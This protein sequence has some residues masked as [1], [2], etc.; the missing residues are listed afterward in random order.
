MTVAQIS[1]LLHRGLAWAGLMQSGESFLAL[2]T[3]LETR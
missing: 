1:N 2:F 3:S